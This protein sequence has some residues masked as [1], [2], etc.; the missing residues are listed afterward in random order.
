MRSLRWILVVFSLAGVAGAQ[1]TATGRAALRASASLEVGAESAQ[2]RYFRPRLQFEFPFRFGR[3][4][5]D[6]DFY[7]RTNGDLEG[8]IDFWLAAG[9]SRPLSSRS[10][11]EALLRHF[12]RHK[13]SRDYPDV[14]DINEVL[15]RFWQNAGSLRLGIGGGTYIGRSDGHDSLIIWNLAWP[16]IFGSEFSAAAE[17]RWVDFREVLYDFEL[18]VGLDSNVDLVG[19]F[20]RHYR[21]P[22]TTYFGLR[23]NSAEATERTIDRFRFRAAFLPDDETRK[24]AAAV[25]FSL[26]FFKTRRSQLLL[27]LNGDIPI[28]RGKAFLASF[29]PEEVQ[30]RTDIVYERRIGP[31]LYAF[32]Y[33]RYDL[34]MPVDSAQRFDS[35][36]GLGLGIKN[37]THFK[38]LDRNFRYVVFAGRNF[39]HGHDAGL[40]AGLNTTGKPVDIGADLQMEFRPG[41]FQALLELFAEAG[42]KNRFR[43]FLGFERTAARAQDGS[44]TRW[45]VGLD[46][47]AWH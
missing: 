15:V 2:R 25:E 10:E 3:V 21:Y 30:Y 31:A 36:W 16:R 40:A 1:D 18:A 20:T 42:G 27:T 46:L 22:P 32:G 34:R 45:L 9:F 26:H 19:R 24:V 23:F 4:F 41:G 38:K 11:L 14:L 7:H 37:Q 33:G 35:S 5:T 12:C 13:T 39:S 28:E 44:F 6:L 8:E 29:R 47:M 43:P 17:A